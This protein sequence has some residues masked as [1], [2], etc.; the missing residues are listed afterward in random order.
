MSARTLD[1]I[2]QSIGTFERTGFRE[3]EWKRLEHDLDDLD[4]LRDD[5]GGTEATRLQGYIF[6]LVKNVATDF[7]ACMEGQGKFPSPDYVGS[8]YTVLRMMGRRDLIDARSMETID[9][10]YT[11]YLAT[12]GLI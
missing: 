1:S 5:A 2:Q 11:S 6:R 12:Q 3:V 7:E 10:N 4:L 8:L 9:T